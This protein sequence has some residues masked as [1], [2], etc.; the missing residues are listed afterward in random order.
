M[1]AAGSKPEASHGGAAVSAEATSKRATYK[2]AASGKVVAALIRANIAED[3]V[4]EY[5]QP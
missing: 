3:A 2:T 4:T 5:W 1:A